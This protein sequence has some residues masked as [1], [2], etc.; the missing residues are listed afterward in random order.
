MHA[1]TVHVYT[2]IYTHTHI[3]CMRVRAPWEYAGR[4]I[5]SR[6]VAWK[7]ETVLCRVLTL[8]LSALPLSLRPNKKV[9]SFSSSA[10][11]YARHPPPRPLTLAPCGAAA[12]PSSSSPS[13]REIR[14][15]NATRWI[16]GFIAGRPCVSPGSVTDLQM[17]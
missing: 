10:L 7:I 16:T 5:C 9:Q 15:P 2:R 3:H 4:V 11:R 17:E 13:P 6:Y 8:S 1:Y 12:S 14:I